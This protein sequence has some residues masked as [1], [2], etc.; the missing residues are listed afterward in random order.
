MKNIT[1]NIILVLALFSCA[2]KEKKVVEAKSVIKI[3]EKIPQIKTFAK[4]T[5]KQTITIDTT[6]FEDLKVILKQEL[7][8]EGVSSFL[9]HSFLKVYKSGQLVDSLTFKNIEAVGKGLGMTSPIEIDNHLVLTKHGSYD[10]RTIIINKEGRVFNFAG[11]ENF[12]N[13]IDK[14]I[15]SFYDSD[16]NG[17][18]VFDLKSDSLIISITNHEDSPVSV[19]RDAKNRI[20]INCVNKESENN[21]IWEVEL[22]ME[23]IMQ[24]DFDAKSLEEMDKLTIIKHKAL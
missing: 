11:G 6:L 14:T 13:K 2:Q 24:V 15:I 18:S 21:S 4:S 12:Y 8:P 7:S 10:G 16:L 17:L 1:V 5:R 20:F 22:D 23:R 19:Y 9:C 3:E